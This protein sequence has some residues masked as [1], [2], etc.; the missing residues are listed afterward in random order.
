MNVGKWWSSIPE[1]QLPNWGAGMIHFMTPVVALF[2]D[3]LPKGV[4]C[5]WSAQIDSAYADR[6]ANRLVVSSKILSQNEEERPNKAANRHEA[7]AAV[8]GVQ[9]HEI[10]HFLYSPA[11][12]PDLMPVGVKSDKIYG[13]IANILEDVYIENKI[14]SEK[15]DLAWM[16][17]EGEWPYFFSAEVGSQFHS[18]WNGLKPETIEDIA[19]AL[20]S[21]C[22]TWR[23]ASEIPSHGEYEDGL[24]NLFMSVIGMTSLD[25]RRNLIAE[26]ARYLN[27]PNIKASKSES[28]KN[29]GEQKQSEQ[30][31]GEKGEGTGENNGQED[32][33]ASEGEQPG[34]SEEGGEGQAV[35]FSEANGGALLPK[36]IEPGEQINSEKRKIVDL[37]NAGNVP[38][39]A[40]V[41]ESGADNINIPLIRTWDKL[42]EL[43]KDVATARRIPGPAGYNGR[44]TSPE[45]MF[46]DG[47]MFSN[48]VLESADGGVFAY[49][50]FDIVLLI[51]RS[52]SMM[53]GGKFTKALVMAAN[54]ARTLTGAGVNVMVATHN[55]DNYQVFE[56]KCDIIV[57][58][59][60]KD[61]YENSLP[62]IKTMLR[63][64]PSGANADADAVT[65][66]AKQFP[67]ASSGRRS[68]MI[69]ISDGQPACVT[70]SG[71]PGIQLTK[72]AVD[73]IRKKG[74]EVYSISVD[75]A[76]VAPN[77][78]IY[79]P[80]FNISNDDPNVA[81]LLLKKLVRQ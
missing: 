46:S 28:Q 78:A 45:R 34:D 16:L 12:I 81:A 67:S 80:Q 40:S 79:G 11:S 18:E 68:L 14:M 38:I 74:I 43:Q 53:S 25:D 26:I 6:D 8:L 51:D 75:R 62:R 30:K 58:K 9:I 64:G 41:E 36:S 13:S 24:R 4:Q 37:D 61:S 19:A 59:G 1:Y 10:F 7:M 17:T 5:S 63:K 35:A 32:D 23:Y 21:I 76:A 48:S 27:V 29:Q 3:M 42:A 72:L 2:A 77:D 66:M 22:H 31:Q 47:R 71:Q 70:Y 44:L 55:T 52:G 49:R 56:E 39:V 33:S 65:Y 60:F 69:V 54:M 15:P 20:T 50:P 57:L 73:D